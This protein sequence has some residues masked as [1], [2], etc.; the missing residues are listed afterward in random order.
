MYSLFDWKG[1]IVYTVLK[2]GP[3][4]YAECSWYPCGYQDIFSKWNSKK[5]GDQ[6]LYP[7]EIADRTK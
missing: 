2:E 3:S 7:K 5:V 1:T 6:P 4:L